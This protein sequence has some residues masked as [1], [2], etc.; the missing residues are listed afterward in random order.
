MKEFFKYVFATVV[1]IIL[2]GVFTFILFFLMLIAIGMSSGGSSVAKHS[3]LK[4]DLAGTIS[5]RAEENPFAEIFGNDLL[6]EQG[7]DDLVAAIRNA[8]VND[9]VEGIYIQGGALATDY[10]SAQELR[11]AILDFKKSKK[12][13]IAYGEQYSQLAYYIATAADT[14]LLNPNGMVDLHGIAAEPIFYKDLLDKIGV[15]M[16]VFRVGTY[17]SAVEPFIATEMSEA[18]REQITSYVN[19]IWSFISKDIAASRKLQVAQINQFADNYIVLSDTKD[20]VKNKLVDQL[21]YIDEVRDKLR[22][23]S[24]KDKVS[25][26]RPTDLID[27]DVETMKALDDHIAVY[28]AAGEIVDQSTT[29][30]FGSETEIV[31]KDVV[32]DLDE[33]A[34]NEKVKA[35]VLRVNSPGG[36]AFASEQMWRAVQKLRQQK[37]VVVSMGGLAASGGYYLSCGADYIFADPTTIT[38]S[39]GIFGLIPDASGLLTEKLGLHFDVVKTNESSDFGTMS[40][41]FNPAESAALQSYIERGYSLFLNRV[42]TGRKKPTAQIDSIAQGRVWTGNQALGIG[43]VDKLGTLNDAIAEAARRANLSGPAVVGYPKKGAWIDQFANLTKGNYLENHLR[44]QLGIYYR[45]LRFAYSLEGRDK[46]QARIPYEP[47]IR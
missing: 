6:K 13:V 46:L 12:F 28:Y 43:L 7:L 42:S 25:F 10:A 3:V 16:Q 26:V 38:G 15:K 29:S 37:P 18:N 36:S 8:A 22:A 39:I 33:L 23:L 47:N 44:Q 24:G 1:G 35:V 40:R 19:D 31:G 14:I 5:E 2:T 9:R 17:K 20:L 21:V 34:Q 45:P 11:K 27:A 4:L 30:A 41:A 32:K